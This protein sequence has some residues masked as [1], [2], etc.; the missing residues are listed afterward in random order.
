MSDTASEPIT[1]PERLVMPPITSIASVCECQRQ[2][3]EAGI[4]RAQVL[5]VEGS[6]DPHDETVQDPGDAALGP[7]ADTQRARSD[8]ILARAAQ[9]KP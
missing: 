9:T 1:A 6:T 5:T 4:E 8:V 2:V 3:E 7:Y